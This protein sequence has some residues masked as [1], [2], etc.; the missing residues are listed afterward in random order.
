MNRKESY[1][2]SSLDSNHPFCKIKRI[3]LDF[4]SELRPV[5]RMR[6]LKR[7]HLP[8]HPLWAWLAFNP[9]FQQHNSR[10]AYRIQFVAGNETMFLFWTKKKTSSFPSHLQ[11]RS[12]KNRLSN[13]NQLFQFKTSNNF[14]I[15]RIKNRVIPTELPLV[16]RENHQLETSEVS[17]QEILSSIDDGPQDQVAKSVS[18]EYLRNKRFYFNYFVTSTTLTTYSFVS[19]TVTKTINLLLAANPNLLQCRPSGFVVCA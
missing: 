11:K 3:R 13:N 9:A 1:Q 12:S 16:K 7:L 17:H 14:N 19:T 4:S 5:W 10:L 18:P 2:T 15:G 8:S 6:C